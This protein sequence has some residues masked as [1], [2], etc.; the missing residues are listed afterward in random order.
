MRPNDC[1]D[2]SKNLQSIVSL[3]ASQLQLAF[4]QTACQL[5]ASQLDL[6]AGQE[7]AKEEEKWLRVILIAG[8]S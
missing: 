3:P 7:E 1:L 8:Y 4:Q 6:C 5:R 2:S